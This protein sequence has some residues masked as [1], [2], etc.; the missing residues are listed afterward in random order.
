MVFNFTSKMWQNQMQSYYRAYFMRHKFCPLENFEPCLIIVQNIC[1]PTGTRPLSLLIRDPRTGSLVT[2]HYGVRNTD[3]GA[4]LAQPIRWSA[5]HWSPSHMES[6]DPCYCK[7][8][9]QVNILLSCG[10]GVTGFWPDTIDPK[11]KHLMMAFRLISSEISVFQKCENLGQ[12]SE[13]K[14]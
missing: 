3:H 5:H 8:I 14:S 7:S 10:F 12:Q 11:I 4:W 6:V 2:G 9:L 13:T 1:Y